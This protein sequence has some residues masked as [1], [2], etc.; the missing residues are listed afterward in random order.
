MPKAKQLVT[1]TMYIS[2]EPYIIV[3]VMH[4]FFKISK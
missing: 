4:V 3:G 2:Q 1:Y